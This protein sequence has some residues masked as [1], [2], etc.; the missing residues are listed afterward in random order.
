MTLVA[1]CCLTQ[2]AGFRL[3][4]ELRVTCS[5]PPAQAQEGIGASCSSITIVPK[6][7][8]DNREVVPG[9]HILACEVISIPLEPLC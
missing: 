6:G 3:A 5:A 9:S 2:A 7:L 8:Q 1:K 4:D